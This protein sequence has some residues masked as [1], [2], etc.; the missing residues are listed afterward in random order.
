MLSSPLRFS[1]SRGHPSVL[2]GLGALL[3]HAGAVS[4]AFAHGDLHDRI[5]EITAQIARQPANA[6]L[7]FKRA[8]LNRQHE[9]W[10]AALADYA[11]VDAI[12]PGLPGVHFGRGSILLAQGKTAAAIAALDLGLAAAPENVEALATRAR[13][14]VALGDVDAAVADYDRALSLAPR[15][16]PDHYLERANALAGAKP[17]R[18]D[19]AALGLEAA[20]TRLGAIPSLGLT[21]CDIEVRRGNFDAALALNDKL[22]ARLKRQE[23]WLERR[24]DILLT[25]GRKAEGADAIKE[26][27]ALVEALPAHVRHTKA[28]GDLEARLRVRVSELAK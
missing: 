20:M 3:I 7:I 9:D 23:S 22:R 28:T 21:L 2:A 17:P 24:G 15:P 13:A 25:A 16:E 11:K 5:V 27:L 26:A 18:L 1:T 19:E 6:D 8:E 4:Q 14:H 12:T 10:P